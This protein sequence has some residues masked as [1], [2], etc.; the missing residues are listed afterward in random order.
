M[1]KLFFALLLVVSS[2]ASAGNFFSV[3]AADNSTAAAPPSGEVTF[4]A[5]TVANGLGEE[6][7]P[8]I[9]TINAPAGLAEGDTML[10][11]VRQDIAGTLTWPSGFTLVASV[12][13]SVPSTEI[14]S[15]AQKVAGASEPATYD[16]TIAT[17]GYPYIR[18][19]MFAWS[20]AAAT[21]PLE[22]YTATAYDTSDGYQLTHTAV[23]VGVATGTAGRK[24]I[25]LSC[26]KP[27]SSQT[28]THTPPASF[29]EL[30]DQDEMG[31]SDYTDTAGTDTGDKTSTFT[32][33]GANDA[34][35]WAF[36]LALTPL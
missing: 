17:G 18:T 35:R 24:L 30:F 8:T 21:T 6:F 3:V 25:Q 2:S 13:L 33:D 20:G 29:T 34:T 12:S 26:A 19:A 5:F 32:F 28:I 1:K 7:S 9:R 11:V 36:L 15:I 27:G 16:I 23:A 4:R 14:V 31:V 10:L 22:D